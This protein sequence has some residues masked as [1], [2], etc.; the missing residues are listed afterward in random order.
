MGTNEHIAANAAQIKA[1]AKKA[2]DALDSAMGAFNKKMANVEEEAKKGRSKLAAQAAAMDKKFR[3]YANNKISAVAAK[4]AAEFHK[5]R[6]Q[7]AKDR[8]AADAA[9]AHTASR[10]NAALAASK[11]L[12]DKR[13]AETVK[14]IAAAKKEANDRVKAFRAGFKADILKLSATAEDQVSKLNGR[15]TQLSGLSPRTRLSRRRSTTT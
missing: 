14:N 15:V 10:M 12:Q 13:F 1:N 2:R 5:V 8:A 9:I 3:D 7:M 11:A 4:T 6:S